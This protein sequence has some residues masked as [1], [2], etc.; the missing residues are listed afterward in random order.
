MDANICSA[1]GSKSV[2]S[3]YYNGGTRVVEPFC[4]G[5]GKQGQELLRAY[6]VGGYSESGNPVGWKLFRADQ[7]SNVIQTG[8]HFN[9]SRPLYNPLDSAMRIIH[10]GV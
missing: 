5:S 1:I 6:Q 4:H 8:E 10:C 9:G 2:I 7:I 3:F